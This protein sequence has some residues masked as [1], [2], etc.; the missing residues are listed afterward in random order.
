MEKFKHPKG[1]PFFYVKYTDF[2]PLTPYQD[3]VEF[4]VDTFSHTYDEER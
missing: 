3:E 2:V 4:N 1:M